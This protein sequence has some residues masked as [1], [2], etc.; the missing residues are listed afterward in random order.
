MKLDTWH[1]HP[2]LVSC[3]DILSRGQYRP[4]NRPP[5][6]FTSDLNLLA[7]LQSVRSLSVKIN[8]SEVKFL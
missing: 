3:K 4:I 7:G 8:I 1:L 5:C 2:T 6:L